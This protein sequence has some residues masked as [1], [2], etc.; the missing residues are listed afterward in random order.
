MANSTDYKVVFSGQ[1]NISSTVNKVKTELDS[2]GKSA[3]TATERIDKQFNRIINSSAPLKRQLRDLQALM[4]KMNFEGLS[5]TD[6]FSKIAAEAGRIKDAISDAAAATQ[7]FASDTMSLQAGVQV[8]QGFA[9][10]GSL[11][12]GVMGLFGTKNEEVTRAIL[13]VQS[14]MAILNGVQTIANLLNKDSILMLKLKSVRQQVS[15]AMTT[16]ETIATTANTAATA[17]NTTAQNAWNVAKA[18][19]KAMFGDFTGLIILGTAAVG[20]YAIATSDAATQEEERTKTLE[21]EKEVQKQYYDVLNEKLGTSI[22]SYN[23]LTYEYSNLKTEQEKTEWIKENQKEFENLGLSVMSVAQADN[24]LIKGTENVTTALKARA[25]IAALAA[26]Y[27]SLYNQA[28]EGAHVAGEKLDQ[29]TIEK[30]FGTWGRGVYYTQNYGGGFF[31]NGKTGGTLTDKGA[32]WLLD[33]A[34][35]DAEKKGKAILDQIDAYQKQLKEMHVATPEINPDVKGPKK[36]DVKPKTGRTGTRTTP[37][38][39]P[40]KEDTYLKDKARLEDNYN[41]KL[42]TELDYKKQLETL[43]KQHLDSLLKAGKAT[44]ADVDRY[45]EAMKSRAQV[46][47]KVKYDEDIAQLQKKL[48]DGMIDN[49][50]YANQYALIMQRIYDDNLKIGNT[51]QS[52]ADNYKSALKAV[53]DMK[54]ETELMTKFSSI[55]LE[56]KKKKSSFDI[57]TGVKDNSGTLEGIKEQM[58]ANDSLIS[59]LNELILKFQELGLTGSASYQQVEEALNGVIEKN[60]GLA[61]QANIVKGQEDHFKKQEEYANG[62]ADTIGNIGTAFS[63]LSGAMDESAQQWMQ[64][65]ATAMQGIAD[66][67]P[68]I[69]SL[70]VAKNAEAMGS[71]TAEGAKLPFPA[72]IAAIASGIAIIASIFASLPK[73]AEGGIIGGG[74]SMFGDKIIARVNP[75]EMILNKRQQKNLFDMLDNG[76]YGNSSQSVSFRI[77]GSDLYGTLKNFSKTQAKVGKKTGIL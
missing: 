17:A 48:A 46:E 5:N 68:L 33:N 63:N 49:T 12:S 39:T 75:G 3:Q 34:L 74:K 64:F 19:G 57:A 66:L 35:E 67:I 52:M 40:Q 21:R 71:V 8:M 65:T 32:Q 36:P 29:E 59:Q 69:R 43:E 26:K 7:R 77:K 25:K 24:V 30:E 18:I 72:N 14:A 55:D 44:Q 13:K 62:Y 58:D 4:A 16:K 38:A 1:D 11:A 54:N 51:S 10:A 28:L 42:I 53:E 15:A 27:Q 2:V 61:D 41:K 56:V 73:F 70:V 50:E 20:A 47:I 60:N 6:Q 31:G 76:G 22:A 37:K 9:A 45:A 23:K